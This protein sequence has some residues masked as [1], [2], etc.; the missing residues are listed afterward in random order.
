MVSVTKDCS[1]KRQTI[2][3]DEITDE[4]N[5]RHFLRLEIHSNKGTALSKSSFRMFVGKS[6][7]NNPRVHLEPQKTAEDIEYE[8]QL[9]FS[10]SLKRDIWGGE[11]EETL[12]SYID[13]YQSAEGKS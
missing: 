10:L 7:E 2:Y 1:G 13:L 5:A 3:A 11:V 12:S 9:N 8:K 6:E 4:L